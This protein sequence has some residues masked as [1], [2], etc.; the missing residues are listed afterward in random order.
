MYRFLIENSVFVY[1]NPANNVLNF[2]IKNNVEIDEISINDISGKQIYKSD[3]TPNNAIDV[4]GFAS[5]VYFV[6]F[7]SEDSLVTKKFIKE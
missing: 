1:P 5:G 7:K 4:S 3:N 6:T 2:S